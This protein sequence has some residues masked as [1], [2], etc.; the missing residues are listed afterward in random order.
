MADYNGFYKAV[1][2]PKLAVY[3]V[4]SFLAESFSLL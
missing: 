3:M 2:T 4:G 1:L